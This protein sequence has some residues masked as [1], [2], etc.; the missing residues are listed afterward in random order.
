LTLLRVDAEREVLVQVWFE[1][2]RQVVAVGVVD[3]VLPI[4]PR[5]DCRYA[6]EQGINVLGSVVQAERRP[7][8][9][10]EIVRVTGQH[11]L[12]DIGNFLLV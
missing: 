11:S 1:P 6:L 10:W 2:N 8:H 7:D 4:I 12:P 3:N 5:N 9:A